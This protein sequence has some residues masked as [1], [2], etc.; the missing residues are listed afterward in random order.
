LVAK[1][2]AKA[3]EKH[4]AK[5]SLG[6]R[7]LPEKPG[8]IYP[9]AGEMPWCS[10][11]PNSGVVDMRFEVAERKVKVRRKQ[12]FYLLDGKEV[13]LSAMDLM[14]FRVFGK[15]S[16]IAGNNT[17]TEQ[18]LARIKRR[19]RIVEVEEVQK[20]FHKFQAF[21]PVI[22]FGWE[23]R[24]VDGLP[25]GGTGL[26]KQLAISAGLVHLPQTY[27]LQTTDGIRATY[28]IEF[29]RQNSHNSQSLFF[30]RKNILQGLLRERECG[31][32]WAVWGERELSYRHLERARLA[33]APNE[34]RYANFQ[35]VYR[36]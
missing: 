34:P 35:A 8:I 10:T 27:D 26:T 16:I 33:T 7:W 14:R 2:E 11:F 18:E 32:V 17:L 24:N 21:I 6:G 3:F 22:N 4:L 5:Q 25:I 15:D 23:G 9:F 29:Q 30:I 1:R 28:G 13:K 31:L 12:P 20:E 36:L 19:D